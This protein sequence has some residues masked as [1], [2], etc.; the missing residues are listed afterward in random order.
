MRAEKTRHGHAA[1]DKKT[2]EYDAWSGM[3]SRCRN[4]SDARYPR[5]GARGITVCERWNRFENFL[6]D[7]GLRPSSKH[8]LDRKENDGN[9]TPE[10]CQWA[11]KREQANNRRV[12]KML[13]YEDRTQPL[14]LW[15]DEFGISQITLRRRL[16]EGMSVDDALTKPI[17]KSRR[18]GS[19]DAR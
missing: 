4:P 17:R 13:T 14:T 1:N 5:Y 12:T 18:R 11:T 6:E 16:Q 7:M 3:L 19:G 10:N 2:P 15:A 8:S 9:Y